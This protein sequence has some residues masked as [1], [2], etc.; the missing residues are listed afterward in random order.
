MLVWHAAAPLGRTCRRAIF[1]R[2][3]SRGRRAGRG[4]GDARVVRSRCRDAPR[5]GIMG[6][7]QLL[8]PPQRALTT[9][10][11]SYGIAQ[12]EP[13][14]V[15][16]SPKPR[17]RHRARARTQHHS[18]R[19]PHHGGARYRLPSEE[20]R[21]FLTPSLE[22]DW[23]DPLIIPGMYEVVA[24]LDR[25]LDAHEAIAVFGDF[26]VDGIT[27]TCLLTEAL[28]ALGGNV[29]PFIPASLRRG[30]RTHRGRAR[31]R[32]RRL[33][34]RRHRDGGQRHRRPRRGCLPHGARHR[35]RGDRPP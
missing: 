1:D 12:N 32:H 30:L 21:R 20:G 2:G 27:S 26:D 11:S 4:R 34:A 6:G 31:P 35:P 24:R 29:T 3:G 5:N 17:A 10:T 8:S 18:A 19:R 25:A 9:R 22:R 28:R 7:V 16:S 33:R 13:P 15:G 14:L 23:A